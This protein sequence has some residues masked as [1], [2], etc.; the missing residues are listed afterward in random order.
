VSFWLIGDVI[1]IAY[2]IVIIVIML[3]TNAMTVVGVVTLTLVFAYKC[4]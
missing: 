1:S 2:T 3:A 4:H